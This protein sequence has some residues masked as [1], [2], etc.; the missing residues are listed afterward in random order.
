MKTSIYI[1]LFAL[2]TILS[3]AAAKDTKAPKGTKAPKAGK[4]VTVD[5]FNNPDNIITVEAVPPPLPARNLREE[6]PVLCKGEDCVEP[7]APKIESIS[8]FGKKK[9]LAAI[10][11]EKFPIQ[12]GPIGVVCTCPPY[13]AIFICIGFTSCDGCCRRVYEVDKEVA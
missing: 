13:A 8:E 2:I 7:I 10:A 4:S 3:L 9:F 12:K 1:K 5:D 11:E 6:N